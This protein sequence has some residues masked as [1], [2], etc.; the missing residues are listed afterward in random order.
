MTCGLDHPGHG[1]AGPIALDLKP[2]ELFPSRGQ[3]AERREGRGQE[4]QTT[5]RVSSQVTPSI[6]LVP[7]PNRLF[8]MKSLMRAVLPGHSHLSVTHSQVGPSVQHERLLKCLI[9]TTA[10]GHRRP[11]SEGEILKLQ[12]EFLRTAM[13]LSLIEHS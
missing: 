8:S 11:L 12:T 2:A 1:W 7:A 5:L 13:L 9:Q 6:Q 10:I 4:Q 3:G